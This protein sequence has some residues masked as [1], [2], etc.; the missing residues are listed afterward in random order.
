MHSLAFNAE[1]EY[2][3]GLIRAGA[4]RLLMRM[5]SNAHD[6][7]ALEQATSCMYSLAR[8]HL[9][10]KQELVKVRMG[11]CRGDGRKRDGSEANWGVGG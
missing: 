9:A 6:N 11:A 8:E 4:C 1:S 2:K 10:A 7:S 3:D 5:L